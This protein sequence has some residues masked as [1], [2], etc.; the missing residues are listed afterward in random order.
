MMKYVIHI[1]AYSLPWF[2]HDLPIF[3]PQGSVDLPL[4]LGEDP[5]KISG[6]GNAGTWSEHLH[7]IALQKQTDRKVTLKVKQIFTTW[8]PKKVAKEGKSPYFREIYLWIKH[9]LHG[10]GFKDF[11][12]SPLLGEMIQFD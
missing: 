3:A 9:V 1:F 7:I 6:R 5:P 2:P 4:L 8:A 11:L 10:G 12:F